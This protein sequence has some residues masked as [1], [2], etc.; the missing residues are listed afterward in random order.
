L[1]PDAS[2][3]ADSTKTNT[4]PMKSDIRAILAASGSASLFLRA[5]GVLQPRRNGDRRAAQMK[6][7]SASSAKVL[8]GTALTKAEETARSLA[9]TIRAH[10]DAMVGVKTEPSGTVHELNELSTGV[11][12]F[13]DEMAKTDRK[14]ARQSM[15]MT[16]TVPRFKPNSLLSFSGHPSSGSFL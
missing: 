7:A 3:E 10:L 1:Y 4:D 2:K 8:Y 6:K 14:V 11:A 9:I 16:R 13:G 15:T 12:G 5:S